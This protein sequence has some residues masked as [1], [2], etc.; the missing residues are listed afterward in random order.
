M[1]SV[2]IIELQAGLNKYLDRVQAGE[3][4]I[5]TQDGVAAARLIPYVEASLPTADDDKQ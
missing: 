2:D 5:I 1:Q 3:S 4:F